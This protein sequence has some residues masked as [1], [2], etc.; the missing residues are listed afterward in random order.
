MYCEFQIRLVYSFACGL[1][2]LHTEIKGTNSK[3]AIAHRDLKT[4]NILVR[5]LLSKPYNP[6]IA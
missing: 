1:T 5:L 4:R 3:H 6:A 2:H